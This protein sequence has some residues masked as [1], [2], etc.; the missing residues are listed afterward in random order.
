MNYVILAWNDL[1]MHC[2]QDDYSYF[3]ILPPF[4]TLHAQVFER[5]EV[6]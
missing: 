1:G 3:L 4:N 6:L 2:A 5:G